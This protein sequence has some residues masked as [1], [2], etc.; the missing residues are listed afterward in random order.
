MRKKIGIPAVIVTG[1]I[2]FALLS[3]QGMLGQAQPDNVLE[4]QV[5]AGSSNLTL[6][7]SDNMPLPANATMEP[8]KPVDG[9]QQLAVESLLNELKNK[10][11]TINQTNQP[12]WYLFTWEVNDDHDSA[13]NGILSNGVE[14]PKQYSQETWVNVDTTGRV[15]QQVTLMKTLT[16]EVFQAGVSTNGK[17][18]NST[19]GE[20]RT[21]TELAVREMLVG[22]HG[23]AA[24]AMKKSFAV[25]ENRLFDGQ[26]VIEIVI[27]EHYQEPLKM[28]G[29]DEKITQTAKRYYFSTENGLLV[30][31]ETIS[32]LVGSAKRIVMASEFRYLGSVPEPSEEVIKYLEKMEGK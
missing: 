13:N 31:E 18:W 25:A 6:N 26:E 32:T 16:G 23:E 27:T 12:G 22:A 28:D 11:L 10:A 20:I 14:I 17:T 1:V 21:S 8:S 24:A 9:E 19:T 3:Q 4:P 7:P 29:L 5:T 15:I 30:K 2:L